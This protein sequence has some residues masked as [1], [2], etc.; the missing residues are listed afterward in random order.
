[1]ARPTSIDPVPENAGPP[2]SPLPDCFQSRQS[3][4]WRRWIAQPESQPE[5]RGAVE[6]PPVPASPRP[7]P[8]LSPSQFRSDRRQSHPTRHCLSIRRQGHPGHASTLA[9]RRSDKHQSHP[10]R[11]TIKCAAARRRRSDQCSQLSAA[12][13]ATT[14]IAAVAAAAGTLATAC[15][16]PHRSRRRNFS[17]PP[18]S[19]R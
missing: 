4:G 19:P 11:R 1:M 14:F 2:G 8:A 16:H 5:A 17:P 10:T 18:P 6:P 13:G 3:R 7:Q 15:H 12:P 9:G